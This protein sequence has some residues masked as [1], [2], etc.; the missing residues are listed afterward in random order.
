MSDIF[1]TL[2]GTFH[3]SHTRLKR[4]IYNVDSSYTTSAQAIQQVADT[5][6]SI[7][8]QVDVK[9][10]YEDQPTLEYTIQQKPCCYLTSSGVHLPSV[11]ALY[12]NDDH[13]RIGVDPGTNN[14]KLDYREN[15]T[16]EYITQTQ[17]MHS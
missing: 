10:N 3:L 1:K 8:A 9:T 2:R 15:N 7:L 17:Y 12:F 5:S 14:L 16:S 4:L 13:W 11:S 6:G